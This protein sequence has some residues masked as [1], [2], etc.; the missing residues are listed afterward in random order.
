MVKGDATRLR[1]AF[2]NLL[3]NA[4]EAQPHG[5]AIW[6]N[7]RKN[8]SWITLEFSDAGPGIPPERRANLFD[9]GESTKPG[10]S[11]IGLPLSQLIVEAH[12]GTLA[13]EA[14][15]E[16]AGGSTFRLMLALDES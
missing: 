5:G 8:G 12:G 3:R 6:V 11:G 16:S 10:G 4:V 7:G 14:N 9:F 13:Y 1:Q 2:D 15:D